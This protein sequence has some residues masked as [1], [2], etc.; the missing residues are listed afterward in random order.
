MILSRYFSKGD[1]GTYKQVMYVYN[2]LLGVFSLGLPRAYS[3]FI[4]K[5]QPS[6]VYSLINK[7]SSLFFILG[8]VFSLFLFFFSEPIASLL[9]NPDLGKALRL[10]SPTPFLLLPTMGLEGVY[11]SFRK[12]LYSSVYTV[13]TR[14]L[15]VFCTVSPVLFFHGSYLDSIIGFDLASLFACVL[16]VAL[17]TWPVKNNPRERTSVTYKDI[18]LFSLPLLYASLWGIILASANQFFVSRFFGKEVFAEFS[19]GYT[20]IPVVGMVLSAVATILLPIF[21][22]KSIDGQ[23]DN[24]SVSLWRAA[25]VKSAKIIYPILV[26]SIV[27]S[28]QFMTCLYGNFYESSYVY[29]IIKNVGG[30]FFIIPFAPVIIAIGKTRDYA[31][32]HMIAAIAIVVL[33]YLCVSLFPSP[34]LIA[35]ISE[36]CQLIKIIFLMSVIV[37]YSDL[38]IKE[39]FPINELV[40]VLG[41]ALGSSILARFLTLAFSNKFIVLLSGSLFC[42]VIY[43][44]VCFIF[45]LSY[46]QIVSSFL[47]DKRFHRIKRFIP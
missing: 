20:E 37:R 26:F 32:A 41:L 8:G 46:K 35:I 23:M 27:F 44:C 42:L 45:K 22:G 36:L 21:S 4:P 19:N 28:K 1:Y 38:S 14:V 10:F 39:F 47:G 7:I 16:A 6:E 25:L 40:K 3:Y 2:T 29:F 5:A 11:A 13:I 18:L 43:Y 12:T 9:A 31:N 17:K 30:L 15:V 33:E 24:D 34:V